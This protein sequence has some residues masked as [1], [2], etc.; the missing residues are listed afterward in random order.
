MV[1][2]VLAEVSRERP[3][4]SEIQSHQIRPPGASVDSGFGDPS[5]SALSVKTLAVHVDFP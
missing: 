1:P 3:P 5:T 2:G 4:V